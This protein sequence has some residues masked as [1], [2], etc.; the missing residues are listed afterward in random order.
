VRL[1]AGVFHTGILRVHDFR[2][3]LR[4]AGPRATVLRALPDL[5]VSERTGFFRA[6]PF[7]PDENPWPYLL[8]LVEGRA[9]IRDLGILV[10][11]PPEG[12]RP[13]TGWTLLEGFDPAFELR[14]AI[15]LTGRR[16]VDFE[17]SRVRVEAERDAASE[18]ET[19]TYHG[20]E[21][22][23]LLLDSEILGVLGATPLWE[24]ARAR[25]DVERSRFRAAVAVDVID[26]DRS[27]VLVRGN[28][29]TTSARGV[30]VLQN[31]DGV[32]SRASVI[33]VDE[34]EGALLPFAPGF[35]DGV[36]FQDP[37]DA[38]PEPGGTVVW[39]TRNRLAL[40][41][42]AD[43]VA[44]GMTLVGAARPKLGMNRLS[45]RA[46]R[47]VDLDETQRCLVLGNS[48]RGLDTAGGPDLRLGGGTSDCLAVVGRDDVVVDEGRANRVVRRGVSR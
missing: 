34:N 5:P 6:D 35:G 31:L 1:C 8:Q 29:W 14:G 47:G 48:F 22:S 30:Q 33:I 41:S 16:S 39:A 44:S 21:F 2:G 13:T 25:V 26:V 7:D 46:A 23:G 10:P 37:L 32:P 36:F 20:V 11:A 12:S 28:R 40:G 15:L 27:Q 24:L 4:G 19:T 3:T 43:A 45:G 9:A 42:G 17:V 18:L 38:S